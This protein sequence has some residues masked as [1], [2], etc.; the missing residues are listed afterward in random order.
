VA[1]IAPTEPLIVAALDVRDVADLI[2]AA[3]AARAAP[4]ATGWRLSRDALADSGRLF[5][6]HPD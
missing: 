2:P 6:R 5:V 1:A 3:R 4:A